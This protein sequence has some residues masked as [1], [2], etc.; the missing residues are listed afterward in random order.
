[1]TD[2]ETLLRARSPRLTRLEIQGFKSFLHRTV[3]A[4]EPGITAI[5]GPNGSGKSNVADALRWVLGEQGQQA[6]RAKK[7]EDVI[8]SGGQGRAPAGMAEVTLTFDN[9]EGWLPSEFAEVSVTRRAFRS[10]EN[11]Y[12]INGRRVRLKDVAMLTS[13]LGQS[14]VVVGQGLV[15]AALSLRAE[16]RRGMFE[17]AADLTG[18]RLKV[19]EAERNLAETEA[20]TARLND[21]LVELEPRLRSL[22]RAARQAREW[23]GLRDRLRR[24]QSSHYRDALATAREALGVAEREAA[25]AAL[26]AEHAGAEAQRLGVGS[27]RASERLIAARA[28]LAE[29]DERRAALEDRLRRQTHERDLAAARLD[30]LARRRADMD[31]ARA[32]LDERVAAVAADL[33]RLQTELRELER[34]T[35]EAREAATRHHRDAAAGRASRSA[36]E[37][38]L[39]ALSSAI[40]D[41]E[42]RET[43]LTRQ[44]AVLLERGEALRGERSRT[45]RAIAE[46]VERIAALEADVS[47]ATS[48]AAEDE[49]RLVALERELTELAERLA[50]ANDRTAAAK[51]DADRLERELGAATTRLDVLRKLRVSGEGLHA[52]VRDVL[53]ASREGRLDGVLGTVAELLTV[54]PALE[55]AIEAALGG[56]LQDIVVATWADAEAAIAMLK[57]RG[58]G[59]ATFQPID[60]VRGGRIE[61]PR[62]GF[63]RKPGVHGIGAELVS[64]PNEIAGVIV[65]LLGRTVVVDALPTA[66]AALPELPAGWSVVTLSGEIA[67]A[68][69]SLTGGARVR[70]SG[71]LGREREL[72]ELPTM[73]AALETRV[74]RARDAGVAAAAGAEAIADRQRRVEGDRSSLRAAA[75]ERSRQ[76]DRLE[77]W[78]ADQRE[79]HE[80]AQRR[81]DELGAELERLAGELAGLDGEVAGLRE[82]RDRTA[83]E[84][85]AVASEL[86]AL[87][88]AAAAT[89]RAEADEGRRLAGLEERVRG[90]RRREAGLRAQERALAEELALRAE[91]T[92]ALDRER[93]HLALDHERLSAESAATAD[94]LERLVAAREPLRMEAMGAEIAAGRLAD[95]LQAARTRL[96]DEER[97]RDHAGFALER[98]THDME[99][100]RSRIVEELEVQDADEVLAFEVEGGETGGRDREAEIARVRERLRRTGYAGDDAVADYERE[101]AQQAHLREQLRDVEGAS[102]ALR[103]LLSELR[104]TMRDRF[105][106]TFTQVAAA[107]ADAFAILFGGGTARLVLTGAENGTEPGIEI[108]AQPPGKRLQSLALLSGGERALTAAALLFAIL[109]VNP[110]PFCLLDEVDAALDEANVVRFRERLQELAEQT[111][112]V[113]VTHNRGTIEIADTLYGVSMSADGVSQ[114]LS[115]RISESLP[116]D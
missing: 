58:S 110:T 94:E 23:Q 53:A 82:Q 9:S 34:A 63:V 108:V 33:A 91:R 17:H 81:R 54:P 97:R 46:R 2:D 48:L 106:E 74:Q 39:G 67:R 38:R 5:V 111:Q 65:A 37:A 21:L 27:E 98:A 55:V 24:L 20:N 76:G 75:A 62:V 49:A 36:I 35:S 43:E 71:T 16:E 107:F 100:L 105:D 84:R 88:T 44:R 56:R 89:E 19:A 109:K 90:E 103:E 80:R 78:L 10:G 7:T 22:E 26:A 86:A 101:A 18:L 73:V 8:F 99:V 32:G 13:G 6:L 93:N 79:E 112:I 50:A 11:Q 1:M 77:I 64:G 104:Q 57:Q 115:L 95:A 3:F 113:V 59:R 60:T 69:G 87:T 85:D 29:H 52:G 25:A 15:D 114:V 72:R 68:G 47:R 4:F 28:G 66:R 92:E 30:S 96:I 70:E 102:A 42:R 31:D 14:H 41:A 51:A 45:E 12:S 116:A 40:A 83:A 61:P